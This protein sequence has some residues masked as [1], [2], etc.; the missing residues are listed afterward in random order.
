MSRKST[1]R[2]AGSGN[3]RQRKDGSWEGRYTNG[4]DPKTGKQLRRSIYG[5]SQREVAAKL[6]QVT[7]EIDTGTYTAPCQLKFGDWMDTWLSE[8]LIGLSPLTVSSYESNCRNY[9]RPS[10]GQA[11]LD[12]ISPVMLQKFINGLAGQGLSPKTIKNI[13][14]V[15]H[16]ALEQAVRIGYLRTNPATI[17]NLPKAVKPPI[18]PLTNEQ[19]AALMSELESS[20]HPFGNLYLLTLF[21]GMRQGEVLGLQWDD[22]DFSKGTILISRQLRKLKG[23]GNGYEFAA[24]KDSEYRLIQPS[25]FVMSVLKKQQQLQSRMKVLADCAWDN[26]DNLIFTNEFGGHLVH[27]TVYKA[28]KEIVTKLGMPDRRF[29]D[30]RHTFAVISLENGDDVKTVQQNLGHSTASFTLDV[31]GHVSDRM[32]KESAARMDQF[33]NNVASPGT[34]FN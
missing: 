21:T 30:L 34:D 2:E 1:R 29:H 17:C 32:R 28:F 15:L 22:V 26:S 11:R 19:V 12:S 5:K 8:Y 4:F 23:R 25:G 14:G 9:I 27:V 6:R 10:L 3:I 20:Q 7:H 13:H 31:Y 33:I 24:P 18:Q 16:R